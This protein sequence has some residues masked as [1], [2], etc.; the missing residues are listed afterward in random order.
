M[1]T[2]TMIGLPVPGRVM[3]AAVDL[4]DAACRASGKQIAQARKQAA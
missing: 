3:S 1:N 2:T 4:G